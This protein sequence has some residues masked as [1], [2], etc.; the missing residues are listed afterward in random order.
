MLEFVSCENL[1]YFQLFYLT[2]RG[3]LLT[4]QTLIDFPRRV[5]L[6]HVGPSS[7]VHF[8]F[9]KTDSN[10]TELRGET[11]EHDVKSGTYESKLFKNA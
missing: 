6:L 4:L 1:I 11:T 3:L 10:G 9:F 7:D 2:L 5:T 8:F